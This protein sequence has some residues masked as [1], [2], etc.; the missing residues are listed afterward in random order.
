MEELLAVGG[1]AVDHVTLFR[2]VQRLTPEPNAANL[3]F[4]LVSARYERL[5]SLSRPTSRTARPPHVYSRI[6]GSPDESSTRFVLVSA[7]GWPAN[8]HDR[9]LMVDVQLR[10]S[11]WTPVSRMHA[12]RSRLG[13]GG[14]RKSRPNWRRSV[15]R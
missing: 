6:A 13:A 15:M 8:S 10:R 12:E 2:W 3:F 11:F 1:I 4:Q 7:L 14:Y 9:V 5:P